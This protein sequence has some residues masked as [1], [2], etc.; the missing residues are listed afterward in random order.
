MPLTVIAGRAGSGKSAIIYEKINEL[1][2]K[3]Q[4]AALL[5]PE[6]F[7]LQAERELIASG[8]GKGFL[9]INVM[10][11]SRLAKDVFS[12][13]QNP[14]QK[15]IDERGK[16]A[17]L[18]SV[19]LEIKD[20]LS[21]F[22]RAASFSG[23]A[24]EAAE[25]IS[26]FKKH[27]I[28]PEVL[29]SAAQKNDGHASDKIRD[30]GKIYSAFEQMLKDKDYIDADS[31][32]DILAHTLV[33]AKK[34]SSTHFFMDGFDMLTAQELN[35]AKALLNLS[36]NLT[37]CINYAKGNNDDIFYSGERTLSDLQK[38]SESTQHSFEVIYAQNP[39]VRKHNS[40]NHLE[41]NLFAERLEVFSGES[42]IEISHATSMKE[43][44][45][46]V[47]CE[48]LNLIKNDSTL[49][50]GDISILCCA[51]L[52]EYG[53]LFERMFARY[54]I[55]CFTHR[56]K[57]ISEH[58]A[59]SYIL[60]AI[61]AKTYNTQKSDMLAMIKSGYAGIAFED[62]MDFED[63]VLNN[64]IDGYLF[65]RPLKR[66]AKKYDLYRMNSIRQKLLAPLNELS[67]KKL[68]AREHLKSIFLMIKAASIKKSLEDEREKLIET[69]AHAYAALTSQVYNSIIAILEQL[70]TLFEDK[71]MTLEQI[72]FALEESFISTQIGILP[73]SLDEVLIGELGRTKLAETKHLFIIGANEGALPP[74]I[75]QN[76]ILSDWDID[77]LAQSGID[78]MKT[79]KARR[80]VSDYAIYQAFSL[81]SKGLHLS[82]PEN[83]SDGI[84]LPSEIVKQIEEMFEIEVERCE[85]DYK[86]SKAAALSV[87]AKAFGA[88]GDGRKP[89]DGWKQ[90]VSALIGKGNSQKELDKM[91]AFLST[92]S[93]ASGIVPKKDGVIVSSVSQIEQYAGCPF[94]YMV[95]YSLRPEDDP[96]EDLTPAGEGAFLHE[97]MERFGESL[98]LY[99]VQSLDDMQ[100]EKLMEDE[101]NII[102]Q[103]FD[104]QK[105]SRDAKGMYQA[106]RLIKTA[107]HGAI[108]YSK[109]M[110]NSK[111]VPLGQEIEFG[112]KKD[113]GPIEITLENGSKVIITG[114][115]DRL[116]TYDAQSGKLARIVDYKSSTKKVEYPKIESGRQ[117]QLFVY[118]DA[119]L[120]QN[121]EAHASGVFYFPVRKKYIDQDKN[122]KR[123]DKMQG[124][125]VESTDNI[126]A[127]DKDIG[128]LG[129][130]SL[131][132]ATVKKDGSF[133]KNSDNISS[134]GFL[135]VLSYAK[136]KAKQTLTAM[137]A[138]EIPVRPVRYSKNMSQCKYCDFSSICK[139]DIDMH[140]E[141]NE[142]ESTVAKEIILG[143]ED[144]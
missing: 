36:G 137:D 58:P 75:S 18:S 130:S 10:S 129:V 45:E 94:S 104:N 141:R 34:Y 101:A 20:N 95:Q 28:T 74:G 38:L 63:Y 54:E 77:I 67:D 87:A 72:A 23:F 84:K 124:L 47:A 105:L 133:N 144:V 88:I 121:P 131:I 64:A 52:N 32:M 103:S 136:D 46:H 3:K 78:F 60:S 76:P 134:D 99:D 15:V 110:K 11:L 24:S 97:A 50:F 43:E 127:L 80:S 126:S 113:L 29:L 17:A 89:P 117:L 125:F 122:E 48:I 85:I 44:A 30:I 114:K 41:K 138:G 98:T 6:Q 33:K 9:S 56:R 109:H 107:K 81:P 82:F 79:V 65:S 118:M 35:I 70:N 2:K 116:D 14:K 92:P 22:S 39:H 1:G 62:A 40:I 119:Y 53:P 5:V 93:H 13:V 57:S 27:G 91:H 86:V 96:G 128:E 4:S 8:N 102:A 73:A 55:P 142:L 83:T 90:A 100:I 49:R 42:A 12:T 16:A 66:G 140:E 61:A 143:E 135:K 31:R 19:T 26:E 69:G 21:V 111:F 123:N 7:T 115:V 51:K 120:S 71:I 59:V 139:K 132:N 112:E 68:P 108:I 25:L 37:V 106:A